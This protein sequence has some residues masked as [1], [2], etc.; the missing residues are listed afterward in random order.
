MSWRN[1]RTSKDSSLHESKKSKKENKRKLQ[2]GQLDKAIAQDSVS[3][4]FQY[5]CTDFRSVNNNT[6]HRKK[7]P[8]QM[9]RS[10]KIGF[11]I[12]K[13]SS[14]IHRRYDIVPDKFPNLGNKAPELAKVRKAGPPQ[15]RK[16][17]A[18]LLDLISQAKRDYE[19]SIVLSRELKGTL[20]STSYV[21]ILSVPYVASHP[22]GWI[23]IESQPSLGSARELLSMC[24]HSFSSLLGKVNDI[25]RVFTS[26]DAQ[27]EKSRLLSE[28]QD[29]PWPQ[30]IRSSANAGRF[31]ESSNSLE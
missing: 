15:L 29:H 20:V 18:I 13:K 14:G 24:L 17:R 28:I 12:K 6:R 3:K 2:L 8:K 21:G 31:T 9:L 30:R 7:N 25:K 26:I 16:N 27:R 11:H 19:K 4:V 23:Y 5:K 22:D 10:R 1:P